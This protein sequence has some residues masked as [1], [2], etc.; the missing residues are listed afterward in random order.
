VVS[1][2]KQQPDHAGEETCKRHHVK[3]ARRWQDP[4]VAPEVLQ[5]RRTQSRVTRRMGDGDPCAEM[6]KKLCV[7]GP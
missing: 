1:R 3:A 4:S 5:A 6:Q 2:R 7:V